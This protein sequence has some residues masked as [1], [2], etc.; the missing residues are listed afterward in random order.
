MG[1]MINYQANSNTFHLKSN[2]FKAYLYNLR[3]T[4]Y[5]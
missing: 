2:P 3:D 1:D 4:S 5:Q